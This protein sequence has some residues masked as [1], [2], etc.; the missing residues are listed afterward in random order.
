MNRII[1]SI[2]IA[3]IVG[4]LALVACD[5]ADAP[6][7]DS[8][9]AADN[10]RSTLQANETTATD[11]SNSSEHIDITARIRRAVMDDDALSTGAKNATIVTDD[12]GTVTLRGHVGSQAEKDAIAAKATAIVGSERVVNRLVVNP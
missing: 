12:T 5:T 3:G 9:N 10:D 11:Q 4:S 7:T 2:A 1:R 6:R 8:D